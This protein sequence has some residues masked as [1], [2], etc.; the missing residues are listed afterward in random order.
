MTD[1]TGKYSALYRPYHLIGLEL[2]VSVASVALR[3]EPT[4]S[5]VSFSADVVSVAKRNL[6]VGEVLDGE[7]GSTVCGAKLCRRHIL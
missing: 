7:G 5:P 6:G 4:G 1:S 2:G 3:R